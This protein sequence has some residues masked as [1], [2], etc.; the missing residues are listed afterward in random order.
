M[1]PVFIFWAPSSWALRAGFLCSLAADFQ[2]VSITKRRQINH[3]R[4]LIYPHSIKLRSN[5]FFFSS[6]RVQLSPFE[7]LVQLQEKSRTSGNVC[8]KRKCF[9][10]SFLTASHPSA[11][12]VFPPQARLL[13][14]WSSVAPYDFLPV[15]YS[16]SD[17]C[18]QFREAP[19]LALRTHRVSM[20]HWR[21]S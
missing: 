8:W 11:A 1:R 20:A 14:V 7:N 3:R 21:A 19:S 12:S 17:F 5:Y 6:K 15:T 4:K 16:S 13:F 2:W 10:E 18:S 9:E